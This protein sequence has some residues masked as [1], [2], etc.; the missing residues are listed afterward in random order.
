MTTF[1]GLGCDPVTIG[2]VYGLL[3][4][5]GFGYNLA[6]AWVERQGYDEGYTA[7]LVVLGVGVTLC[8]IAVLDFM[9]ALLALGAFAASGFRMVVGSIARHARARKQAQDLIRMGQ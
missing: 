9:A 8:G 1:E 5:F 2:I 3:F 4:G 7:I 6:V